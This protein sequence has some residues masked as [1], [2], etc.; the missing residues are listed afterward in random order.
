MN[1][2]DRLILQQ[3]IK[4]VSA[5]QGKSKELFWNNLDV[6]DELLITTVVTHVYKTH[7][8]AAHVFNITQGTE[9]SFGFGMLHNYLQQFAYT[10]L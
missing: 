7:A 1:H 3:R 10:L 8:P 6:G 2:N 5:Y 9:K 4:V